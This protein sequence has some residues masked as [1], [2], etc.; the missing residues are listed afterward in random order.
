MYVICT[1][2]KLYSPHPQLLYVELVTAVNDIKPVYFVTLSKATVNYLI[3]NHAT[4]IAATINRCVS[5]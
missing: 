5:Y 1:V 2:D 4:K 3:T